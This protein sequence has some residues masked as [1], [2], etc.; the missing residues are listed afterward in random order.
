MCSEWET[1]ER[2]S[3]N[4]TSMSKFRSLRRRG[5]RKILKAR[6][7]QW[8]QGNSDFQTQQGWCTHEIAETGSMLKTQLNSNQE[9]SHHGEG[10]EGTKSH[11]YPRSYLYVMACWGRESCFSIK[12]L[13]LGISPICA[14]FIMFKS[15]WPTHSMFLLC[16]FCY[17]LAVLS[18]WFL[19]C[20]LFCLLVF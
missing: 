18:F 16:D 6:G 5:G 2:S 8:L 17:C 9:K 13:I 14:S 19:F 10:E 20:F 3:L 12:V 1:L 11:S 7:G 15:S 4:E